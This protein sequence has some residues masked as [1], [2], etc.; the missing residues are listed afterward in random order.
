MAF[1]NPGDSGERGQGGGG[2]GAKREQSGQIHFYDLRTSGR[3]ANSSP[4]ISDCFYGLQVDKVIL[5][6]KILIILMEHNYENWSEF[7]TLQF[8]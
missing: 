7:N 5:L 2:G 1:Q 3:V 6:I 4:I 8:S